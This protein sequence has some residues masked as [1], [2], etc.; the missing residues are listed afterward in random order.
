LLADL[1]PYKRIWPLLLRA[2]VRQQAPLRR[3]V[4]IALR[5]AFAAEKIRH[6][7]VWR[8]LERCVLRLSA[9]G[10]AT[11]IQ[12]AAALAATVYPE[13]ALRHVHAV[14]LG[15]SDLERALH[16]LP[17]QRFVPRGDV[18]PGAGDVVALEGPDRQPLSVVLDE[19]A[20]EMPSPGEPL[21]LQPARQA[22]ARVWEET[23]APGAN[24]LVWAF[25]VFFVTR[26]GRVSGSTAS[27]RLVDEAIEVL[28]IVLDRT[29]PN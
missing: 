17:K 3:D 22:L 25:D 24:P 19:N 27:D 1:S 29:S 9:G 12:G 14:R 23:L 7:R 28:E 11:R 8:Q 13:P 10:V 15:V 4:R 5:A 16:E 26:L 6:V 18:L 20:T 2:L 21:A